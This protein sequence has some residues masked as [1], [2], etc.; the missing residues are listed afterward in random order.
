MVW[1]ECGQR[2]GMELGRKAWY[3]EKAW[4][5]GEGMGW[6]RRHGTGR[7]LS[8]QV[9]KGTKQEAQNSSWAQAGL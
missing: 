3:E 6:E 4:N 8:A 5:G 1:E 9:V 2:Y 7:G